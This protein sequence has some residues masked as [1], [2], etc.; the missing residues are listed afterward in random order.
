M[1]V[2]ELIELLQKCNPDDFV[3]YDAQNGIT[4][5]G[6]T[7]IDTAGEDATDKY[8]YFSIDDVQ[9]GYGTLRGNVYLTADLYPEMQ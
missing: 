8:P 9:V 2:S 3:M 6:W 1:K 5:E 7:L 4:N